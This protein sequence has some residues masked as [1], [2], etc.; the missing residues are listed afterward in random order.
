[1]DSSCTPSSLGKA[2]V[3]EISCD[4]SKVREAKWIV[5]AHRLVLP[6]SDIV[7]RDHSPAGSTAAF[8]RESMRR[9]A[10]TGTKT[11]FTLLGRMG[12]RLLNIK[13]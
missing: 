12:D 11:M 9:D 6:A 4:T 7:S 5:P 2:R 8:F 3:S 13:S 10:M 1:M